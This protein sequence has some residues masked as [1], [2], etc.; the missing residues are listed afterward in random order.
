[1]R[2]YTKGLV[3]NG[4]TF[5]VATKHTVFAN[6]ASQAV[7]GTLRVVNNNAAD[8]TIEVWAGDNATDD[9]WRVLP[10]RTVKGLS[11]MSVP[12]V[13]IGPSQLL[14]IQSSAIGASVTFDGAYEDDYTQAANGAILVD[15]TTYALSTYH[16]FFTASAGDSYRGN[17]MIINHGTTN[18][19]VLLTRTVGG[20]RIERVPLNQ[21]SLVDVT[22]VLVGEEAV[23][24]SLQIYS[25]VAN[26]SAAFRGWQMEG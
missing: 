17:V 20:D 21:K 12:A 14:A 9:K 10:Q 8:Q 1:M 25:T 23:S 26:V 6:S 5:A 24:D 16:S 3:V 4:T 22:D 19:T 13:V 2:S 15:G 11:T 7:G 18:G